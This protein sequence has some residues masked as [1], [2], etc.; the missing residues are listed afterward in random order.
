MGGASP[1]KALVSLHTPVAISIQR[2]NHI[3]SPHLPTFRCTLSSPHTPRSARRAVASTLG[4]LYTKDLC[5]SVGAGS[6]LSFLRATPLAQRAKQWLV[7]TLFRRPD[8]EA[9]TCGSAHHGA[10]ACGG[11]ATGL[12]ILLPRPPIAGV[13]GD[14]S[15]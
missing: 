11:A 10:R 1:T 4:D 6:M 12:G 9:R 14:G 3:R 2:R 8:Y 15:E 5:F 13:H 7:R